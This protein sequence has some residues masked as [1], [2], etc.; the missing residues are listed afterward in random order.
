VKL[1]DGE[2]YDA[3]PMARELAALPA[4]ESESCMRQSLDDVQFQLAHA[5]KAAEAWARG[6]LKTLRAHIREPAFTACL[7][8]T[9][10]FRT[11]EARAVDEIVATLAASLQTPGKSVA[12]F[13][14]NALLTRQSGAFD[15]LRAMGY[16]I[17]APAD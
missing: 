8:K 2:D 9:E 12:V 13:D 3:A 17:D 6:D 7:K 11:I 5:H 14:I 1:Q 16:R 15:R 4:S 10:S